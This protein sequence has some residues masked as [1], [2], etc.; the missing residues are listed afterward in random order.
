MSDELFSFKEDKAPLI[1][2]GEP[3]KV[4][5]IDDDEDIH[6]S[7]NLVLKDFIFNNRPIEIISGYSGKDAIDL[8]KNNDAIS[9]IFLDVIM[10]TENAG[11]E[12]V[13]H[14]RE[15]IGNQSVR[16]LL[17]TGQCSEEDI[18]E[19]YDINSFLNKA[20]V[21][22]QELKMQLKG[23]LR[24]FKLLEDMVTAKNSA[25]NA[26]KAKSQFLA[27]MSHEFRT[28]LHGILSYAQ[29]G[30]KRVDKVPTAKLKVYFE[31]IETCGVRLLDLINNLLDIS[32]LEAGKMELNIAEYNVEDIISDCLNELSAKLDSRSIN[33]IINIETSPTIIECDK[34]LFHQVLTN[35]LSN[36]IKHSPTGKNITFNGIII[37]STFEF[38]IVD[39]GVGLAKDKLEIIF[40]KFTQDKEMET[41]TGMGSTGLGLAISKKIIEAHQG[42]IWAE[43]S[44]D[45]DIGGIFK[46]SMPVLQSS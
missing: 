31:N 7:T 34:G 40:K 30:E 17:R 14:I 13:T 3:W 33:I 44:T 12:V 29:M 23:A 5:I 35:L 45:K 18:F 43:S 21:S 8:M 16:I 28:P 11:L 36:A 4:L 39:Q 25:E 10:E 42:K 19:H 46:I 26:N 20:T 38:S 15:K 6:R 22:S 41:G 1:F 27:N 32:K 24:N 9:V 2:H 37:G